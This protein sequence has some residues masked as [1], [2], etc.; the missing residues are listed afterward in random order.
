[1]I[2]IRRPGFHSGFTL[3]EI[4]LSIAILVILFGVLSPVYGYFFNR[5]NLDLA[6]QQL[7]QDLRR[8]QTLAR[9]MQ[10]DNNWGVYIT[11][12]STTIF[13]GA[14]YANRNISYD[15]ITNFNGNILASGTTEIVFLKSTGMPLTI[16]TI[17]LSSPNNETLNVSIN[18]QGTI[19]Y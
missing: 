1:M 8:A 11:G 18:S 13:E 12:S 16:A 10:N 7:V 9:G 15:E 5:N 2:K 14:T 17:I 6:G 3:I 4:L 19:N